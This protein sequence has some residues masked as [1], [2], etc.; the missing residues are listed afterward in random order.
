M[1]VTDNLRRRRIAVGPREG[2]A[3]LLLLL[4]LLIMMIMTDIMINVK[5]KARGALFT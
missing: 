1:K 3:W 2:A 4:L 5:H